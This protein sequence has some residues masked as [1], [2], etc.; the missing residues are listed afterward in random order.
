[1]LRQMAGVITTHEA[2]IGFLAQRAVEHPGI[3]GG[4][5]GFV[6]G[7]LGVTGMN[8]GDGGNDGGDAGVFHGSLGLNVRHLTLVAVGGGHV[9]RSVHEMNVCSSWPYL[10]RAGRPNVTKGAVIARSDRSEPRIF[11]FAAWDRQTNAESR[12]HDHSESLKNPLHGVQ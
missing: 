5:F 8:S 6:D 7:F 11:G 9:Q 4:G 10:P 12:R 2:G 3:E 1:M